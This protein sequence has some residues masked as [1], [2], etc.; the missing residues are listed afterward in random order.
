VVINLSGLPASTEL[1]M[2]IHEFGDISSTDGLAAG[3]H[4]NP[5]GALH[6]C[7]PNGTRHVGDIGSFTTDS[8]GAYA[9]TIVLNPMMALS[10]QNSTI[11]RAVIVHSQ[12]DNCG[13]PTGNAG[14]RI[15]QGVIGIDYQVGLTQTANNPSDYPLQ[16]WSVL[17]AVINPT[18]ALSGN[19]LSG[20][21]WF[22]T[23]PN[24]ATKTQVLANITGASPVS[25][26]HGIHVH[27]YGDLE[28]TDGTSAQG[29]WNPAGVDHALPE[30]STHH[31]GDM[32]NLWIDA[33]GNGV[34]YGEFSLLT[35]SNIVGRAVIVHQSPDQGWGSATGN[36]G[37]RY[38]YGVIG[39]AGPAVTYPAIPQF[40]STGV[41]CI[42]DDCSPA[43]A[44]RASLALVAVL[45]AVLLA[46]LL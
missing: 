13:Q 39:V 22:R 24:D 16:R 37:A 27:Q 38:G 2:H 45:L 32:G 36:A 23:S 44:T 31:Q 6:G 10:G 42:G 9:N 5:F 34:F 15:A 29:H 3:G 18:T 33:N 1:S 4:F 40:S 11:G 19:T 14:S 26:Y 43:A 41:D 12:G 21:I 28:A 46:L 25:A 35:V 30:N 20:R 17:T 7:P 8:S